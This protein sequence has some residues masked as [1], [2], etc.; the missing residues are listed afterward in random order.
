MRWY[1]MEKKLPKVFANTFDEKFQNVQEIYYGSD[2]MVE[3]PVDGTSLEAKINRIFHSARH[4]YKSVV[5]ITTTTGRIEETIVGK[6]NEALI[7]MSGK[8]IPI[9]SILDIQ[10]K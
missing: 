4:V 7:T 8:Q 3:E 6:T 5:D 10:A 9:S 1:F 2:R